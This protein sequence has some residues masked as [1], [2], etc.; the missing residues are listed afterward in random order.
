MTVQAKSRSYAHDLVYIALS[1][2]LIAICSWISIP[3]EVPF[4]LQTMGVFLICGLLGGK[5]ATLSVLVYILL[6]AV[7]VPVFAGFV[8][9]I[10]TLIGPTGGYIVGFLGS[11][12]I[13]WLFEKLFG[14]R[15]YV[16]VAGMILGLLICYALGT[17]WFYLVYN[18][19]T[20]SMGWGTVLS[21]CVLPFIPFDLIKIAL[22]LILTRMLGKILAKHL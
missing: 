16:K 21:L 17:I 14:D 5:R 20:G 22:S 6:G 3:T 13:H 19:R 7:G 18:A 9:G 12:L 4:T 15:I 1:A 2:V 10:S 11:A 8:G